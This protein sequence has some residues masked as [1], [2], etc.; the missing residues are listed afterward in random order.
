M[1]K[2]GLS[3]Y[4]VVISYT[5][6]SHAVMSSQ[7][8]CDVRWTPLL[9]LAG[10]NVFEAVRR[11]LAHRRMGSAHRRLADMTPVAI[12]VQSLSS[13]LAKL[14]QSPTPSRCRTAGGAVR[15]RQ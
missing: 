10:F 12:R 15:R 2:P 9:P 3:V 5:V 1:I 8:S 14:P 7:H 4:R 11:C 6:V 13:V